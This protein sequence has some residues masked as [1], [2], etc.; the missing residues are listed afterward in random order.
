MTIIVALHNRGET[1]VGCDGMVSSRGHLFPLSVRKWLFAINDMRAIA[2]CGH[3][4]TRN[5]ME[6]VWDRDQILAREPIVEVARELRR[7]MKAD[8]IK[9]ESD[10]VAPNQFILATRGGVW[11]IAGDWSVSVIPEGVLW[12]RG[13]GEDYANG[14]GHATR[15]DGGKARVLKALE[16]A[17]EYRGDC[18]GDLFVHR[19]GDPLPA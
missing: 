7:L 18:G 19:L 11:D 1:W 14:A 2:A 12:A 9:D 10:G 5:L 4:F 16:A 3:S 6:S 15:G 8:D 17:C 13:S